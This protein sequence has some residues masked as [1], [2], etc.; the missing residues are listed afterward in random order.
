MQKHVRR[1]PKGEIIRLLMELPEPRAFG[2][3]WLSG[4]ML[5]PSGL[6]II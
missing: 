4:F 1:N 5:P 6:T 2:S 3:L